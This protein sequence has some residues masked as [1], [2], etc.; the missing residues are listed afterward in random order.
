M[1]DRRRKRSSRERVAQDL[2][3]RS[4]PCIGTPGPTDR[5]GLWDGSIAWL[6]KNLARAESGAVAA[7]GTRLVSAVGSQNQTALIVSAHTQTQRLR[8]AAGLDFVTPAPKLSSEERR[9]SI[10]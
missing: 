2:H 8:R 3:S 10:L 1:R 5:S 7:D 9:A 6:S 4:G